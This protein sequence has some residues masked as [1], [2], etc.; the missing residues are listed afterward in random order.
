MHVAPDVVVAVVDVA[1]I[2]HGVQ[3]AEAATD[4]ATLFEDEVGQFEHTEAPATE[5]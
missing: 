5:Y 4:P 3:H 2:E 1:F